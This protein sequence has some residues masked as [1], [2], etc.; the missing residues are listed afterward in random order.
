M[1]EMIQIHH[2]LGI[3]D[4][5]SEE[6]SKEV[7]DILTEVGKVDVGAKKLAETY[8]AEA[9]LAGVRLYQL[10]RLNKDL[11]KTISRPNK[12]SLN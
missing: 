11:H 7:I 4:E 2:A 6:I 3:S 10:I 9:V 1:S 5:R 12:P 8:N